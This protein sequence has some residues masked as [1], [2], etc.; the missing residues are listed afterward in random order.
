MNLSTGYYEDGDEFLYLYPVREV[1]RL[2]PHA[3]LAK[4]GICSACVFSAHSATCKGYGGY[5]G[6]HCMITTG[7]SYAG[8]WV[9]GSD[10]VTYRLLGG[11]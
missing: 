4:N 10:L 2:D 3:A 5:R 6:L 11:V 1:K 9:R 7:A 8:V